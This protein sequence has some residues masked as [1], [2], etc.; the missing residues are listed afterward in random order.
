MRLI[1]SQLLIDQ[2]SNFNFPENPSKFT[3]SEITEIFN[4]TFHQ[5]EL[6]LTFGVSL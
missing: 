1:H 2:F 6:Q 4:V 5:L 3:S